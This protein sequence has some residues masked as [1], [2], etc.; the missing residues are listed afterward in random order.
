[1]CPYSPARPG[2]RSLFEHARP[3]R[4]SHHGNH[5]G[6][7]CEATRP[8][9]RV[10]RQIRYDLSRRQGQMGNGVPI[11]ADYRTR[12]SARQVMAQ[13]LPFSACSRFGCLGGALGMR[14]G[15]FIIVTGL[16]FLV[17]GC[18]S[19]PASHDE[20]RLPAFGPPGPRVDLASALLFDRKPGAFVAS[21]FAGRSDWPSTPA[22]YSPGQVIVFHE[23]FV[24]YQGRGFHHP[25]RS[26]RRFT[27]HR[28]GVGVR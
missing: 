22:Y 15:L 10:G 28:V 2:S 19:P 16:T 24:D 17:A 14:Y 23:R 9:M 27:T 6:R 18:A 21:D 5:T 13:Q 25:D 26:Y 11:E 4:V 1:M 12:P 7:S 8:H 3:V 20:S